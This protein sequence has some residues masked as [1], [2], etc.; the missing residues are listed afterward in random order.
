MTN[1]KK[2]RGAET[3]KLRLQV[4]F[5]QDVDREGGFSAEGIASGHSLGHVGIRRGLSRTV[6]RC[7]IRPFCP[8]T[9]STGVRLV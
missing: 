7:C 5:G 8:E 2:S 4:L 1:I 9:G 6:E 3:M